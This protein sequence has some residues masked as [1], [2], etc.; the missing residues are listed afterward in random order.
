MV[1]PELPLI[2]TCQK[3]SLT[4]SMEGRELDFRI[5]QERILG[6][7][8]T[9]RRREQKLGRCQTTHQQGQ[10]LRRAWVMQWAE[11]NWEDHI[12][13][14]EG[15]WYSWMEGRTVIISLLSLSILFFLFKQAIEARGY[16]WSPGWGW[17]IEDISALA[18]LEVNLSGSLEGIAPRAG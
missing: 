2:S 16:F 1:S 8:K 4:T 18:G 11:P 12:F 6:H 5:W 9:S 10:T 15:L 13:L 3:A 7:R 14:G 17:V